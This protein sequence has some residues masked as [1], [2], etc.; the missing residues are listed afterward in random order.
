MTSDTNIH[1][2]QIVAPATVPAM[3]FTQ[4]MDL[5]S[6]TFMLRRRA[7]LIFT[8]AAASMV[9]ALVI[10]MLM[11]PMYQSK[12][13]LLLEPRHSQVLNIEEVLSPLTASSEVV[14]SE[15]EI[16]KSRAVIDRVIDKLNLTDDVEF[17]PPPHFWSMLNPGN[18]NSSTVSDAEKKAR[19]RARVAG[20]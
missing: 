4:N 20:L 9:L 18:W 14:R 1:L 13:L 7:R 10:A 5:K 11:T 16:I 19:A 15:I 12:T 17:N 8:V 6:A 3:P 2:P